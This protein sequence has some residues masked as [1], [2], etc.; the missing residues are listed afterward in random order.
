MVGFSV[1]TQF[2]PLGLE[3]FYFP[4]ISADSPLGL[5]SEVNPNLVFLICM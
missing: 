1:T 2:E 4:H 3:I 5:D